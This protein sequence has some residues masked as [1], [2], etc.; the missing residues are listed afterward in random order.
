MRRI[1]L[2]AALAIAVAAACAA[3][4]RAITNGEPDGNRHPYV[5]VLLD[6]YETPGGVPV[7]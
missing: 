2:S 3:V 1:V 6:D 7:P 5:G 4:A